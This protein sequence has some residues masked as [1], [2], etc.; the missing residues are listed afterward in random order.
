MPETNWQESHA[1]NYLSGIYKQ[2]QNSCK[3]PKMIVKLLTHLDELD[4]RRGTDW[5]KLFPYLENWR[6]HVV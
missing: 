1:K 2:I 5:K 6:D 4:R 3:N